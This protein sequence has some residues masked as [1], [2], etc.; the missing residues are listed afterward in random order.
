MKALDEAGIPAGSINSV[1]EALASAQAN[2][3]NMVVQVDHPQLGALPLLGLPYLFSN[4]P[5]EIR[6]PPPLLGADTEEILTGL[7][8]S[9]DEIEELARSG[10]T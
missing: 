1:A 9:Q 8:L 6:Y 3:R 2:A 5:A 4:T 10:A 7:G